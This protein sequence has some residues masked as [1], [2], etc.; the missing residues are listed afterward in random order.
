MFSIYFPISIDLYNH[1]D[2]LYHLFSDQRNLNISPNETFVFLSISIFSWTRLAIYLWRDRQSQRISHLFRQ[3]NG[4]TYINLQFASY[5]NDLLAYILSLCCFFGT[6]Q[7]T[8]LCLFNQRLLLFS[9]TRQNA[10]RALISLINDFRS[11]K[12]NTGG[13]S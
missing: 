3:T 13:D 11:E 6:I 1:L 9:E 8:H 5:V 12:S 7:L 4:F 2:D 10:G